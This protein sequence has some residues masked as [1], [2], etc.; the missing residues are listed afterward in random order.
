MC[1]KTPNA[2]I[3]EAEVCISIL[4]SDLEAKTKELLISTLHNYKWLHKVQKNGKHFLFISSGKIRYNA[5]T[6][7][8][9]LQKCQNWSFCHQ[10]VTAQHSQAQKAYSELY[11]RTKI[12][13]KFLSQCL[14]DKQGLRS[15]T[16]SFNPSQNVHVDYITENISKKAR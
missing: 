11:P 4:W 15:V 10:N 9:V 13:R 7:W 1:S 2:P 3:L 8:T 16:L 5:V 14:S 6:Q 12:H